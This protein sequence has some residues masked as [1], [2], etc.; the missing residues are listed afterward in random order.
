[1]SSYKNVNKYGIFYSH[2]I[3][4]SSKDIDGAAIWKSYQGCVGKSAE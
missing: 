3:L 2:E 1:M 4:V